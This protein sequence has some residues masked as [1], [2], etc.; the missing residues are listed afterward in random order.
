MNKFDE[1]HMGAVTQIIS[2]LVAADYK[3]IEEATQEDGYPG[4]Y[5]ERL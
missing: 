5:Y 4:N 3:S 2:W 1:K